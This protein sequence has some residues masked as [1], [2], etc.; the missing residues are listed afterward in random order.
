MRK[1][2]LA[3]H[4]AVRTSAGSASMLTPSA[5]NTSAAPDFEDCARLPCFA[6][7]TP[8]PAATMLVAVEILRVPL[9]S[10]PV[11]QVSTASAASCSKGTIASL[12]A[13]A[14]PAISA[15]VSPRSA[16]A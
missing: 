10:P 13:S 7:G 8:Q 16:K 15:A 6:T 14:A 4:S 5:A 1:Q 12:R 3:S 11:P 9:A 2:I